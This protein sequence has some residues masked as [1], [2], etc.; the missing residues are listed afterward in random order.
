MR[1][2]HAA[3]DAP[4]ASAGRKQAVIAVFALAMIAVH[5]VL[6]F[7]LGSLP[8]FAGIP[9]SQL[10]V[11]AVLLLGGTPLLLELLAKVVRLEH[12]YRSNPAILELAA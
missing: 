2:R 3:E 5:L 12:N 1:T 6:R 7:G 4:A 11:L 8:A 10:P 9:L